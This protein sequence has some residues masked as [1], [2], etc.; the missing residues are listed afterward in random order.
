[1]YSLIFCN[2]VRSLPSLN[3]FILIF[4]I[5]LFRFSNFLH[6]FITSITILFNSLSTSVYRFVHS[7]ILSFVHSSSNIIAHLSI[8]V[9]TCKSSLI[10]SLSFNDLFSHSVFRHFSFYLPSTFFI[11]SP[12]LFFFS[13]SFV[14]SLS[15]MQPIRLIHS[16]LFTCNG[17]GWKYRPEKA[18]VQKTV[19]FRTRMFS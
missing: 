9:S 2:C 11:L 7:F 4:V 5:C 18:I 3:S 13:L 17:A 16:P 14:H 1:M 15:L 6:S 10:L 19:A 8:L 12:F